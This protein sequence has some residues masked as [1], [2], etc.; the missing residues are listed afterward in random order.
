[1]A[2]NPIESSEANTAHHQR[3]FRILNGLSAKLLWLT[4]AFIM[5]A[6]VLIFVPSIA[7]FRDTWLRNHLDTAEA[8]SIV[9]LDASDAMLSDAASRTLLA[10]ALA[11]TIAVRRDGRS[12]LI[13]SKGVAGEITEHIDLDNT[14]PFTSISSAL[15]MLFM[16]PSS[17]YR[18]SGETKAMD[19]TIELVQPLIHLQNALWGYTRNILILSLLISVFAAGLVYLALYRLIV[20]PIIKISTNMDA[21]SREPENA[22]LIYKPTGRADEIGIAEER[23]AAFQ[24]DLRNTLRQKKHLADLGL[25]VSKINHDL[26]NILA[27]A[28]LFSDRLTSLQD[29]TVQRFAPKLIRTID[30]AVGYTK[31][32]IDYGRAVETEPNRRQL[33]LYGIAND[34]SELL[35]IEPNGDIKWENRIDPA[36]ETVADPE[37]LFRALMN[38]CRNAC[39][40][41]QDMEPGTGERVLEISAE[42][43]ADGVN[44][45]VRDTG[46]GIPERI[47]EKMFSAFQASTKAG[48]TGLGLAIAAELVR[49]HGG[50]IEL[51]KTGE[52]GTTFLVFIPAPAGSNVQTQP[53]LEENAA[54]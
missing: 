43:R 52:T 14:T 20:L 1:M 13:A 25:A 40:A 19:A 44:I 54:E 29:P 36:L 7:N 9:Y 50:T 17:L 18:V 28:Q 41:M 6:E 24:G 10:T 4:I 33:A 5:L 37:Q 11:D 8:A 3:R 47:Q 15:S 12:Q 21:F 32:V 23:L 31:A 53:R 51:E 45:R 26:R 49:A 46:P 22:S 27:S 38:L 34:I 30:R 48:G 16:D 35:G 39:Q 2:E 42:P